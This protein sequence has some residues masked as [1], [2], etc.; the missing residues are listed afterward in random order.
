MGDARLYDLRH[1]PLTGETFM[2]TMILMTLLAFVAG[3]GGASDS[4]F[5]DGG[6]AD[7]VDR[8]APFLGSWKLVSGTFTVT[9]PNKPPTT[10]QATSD[11]S[12]QRG[13]T[14]DLLLADPECPLNLNVS[15]NVATAVAGQSCSSSGVTLMV[16]SYT[17]TIDGNTGTE[18]GTAQIGGCASA[19]EATYTRTTGAP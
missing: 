2:R 4:S 7:G 14:S 8:L 17:F 16:Q 19:G 13:T 15:G 18:K 10:Q 1:S 11:D 9:C 12:F 5:A 3:C 6:Q